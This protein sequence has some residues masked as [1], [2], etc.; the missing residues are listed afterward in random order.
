[1]KVCFVVDDSSAMRR[2]QQKALEASGWQVH[3]AVDG[4][5]AIEKL[6]A[7]PTIPD[8]V[9]TDWHMP[10]MDG[11]E[12]VRAIRKDE[13]FKGVRILMVTSDSVLDAVEQAL[14]AGA[15]DFL[16]KPFSTVELTERVEEVMNG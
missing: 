3:A 6:Q 16:M 15:N 11:L 1:M 9:L 4:Q 12:L 10:R 5:D 13:R 8:L 14:A 2:I 7:M